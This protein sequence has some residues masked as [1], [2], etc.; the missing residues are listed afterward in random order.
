MLWWLCDHTKGNKQAH[1]AFMN[2]SSA[3]TESGKKKFWSLFLNIKKQIVYIFLPDL[4][5]SVNKVVSVGD[6]SM[7]FVCQ[8]LCINVGRVRNKICTVKYDFICLLSSSIARAVVWNF[9]FTQFA[10]IGYKLC[11]ELE[12]SLLSGFVPQM[13]LSRFHLYYQN[14]SLIQEYLIGYGFNFIICFCY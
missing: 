14:E 3:G 9:H 10:S 5:I 12:K 6:L 1:G 4:F 7:H 8:W 11:I 13:H 2:E